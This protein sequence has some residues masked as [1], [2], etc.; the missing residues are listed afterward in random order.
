MPGCKEAHGI[1]WKFLFADAKFYPTKEYLR[2]IGITF[3]AMELSD[4]PPNDFINQLAHKTYDLLQSIRKSGNQK[5]LP[6]NLAD[7]LGRR[8]S[9]PFP[10]D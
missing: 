4:T 9:V 7:A 2:A 1:L 6:R 3:N 8:E 10:R 5:K